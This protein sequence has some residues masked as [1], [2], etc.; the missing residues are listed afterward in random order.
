[1]KFG[2]LFY[3]AEGD[4]ASRTSE[5]KAAYWSAWQA[6]STSLKAAGVWQAENGGMALET[7][8]QAHTLQRGHGGRNVQDGPFANTKEQLGGVMVI[9]ASTLDEALTWAARAPCA[10][11][12][13][14][15]VRPIWVMG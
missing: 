9:E 7:P 11:T 1:M 5:N 15:E 10:G 3:E 13:A 14:V 6:Y 12:G 2:L 4:F 8:C